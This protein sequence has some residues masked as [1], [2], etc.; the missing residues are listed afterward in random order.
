MRKNQQARKKRERKKKRIKII[1]VLEIQ[2]ST[3]LPI[4]EFNKALPGPSAAESH[5]SPKQATSR[6]T[7]PRRR[8]IK[9]LLNPVLGEKKAYFCKTEQ[10]NRRRRSYKPNPSRDDRLFQQVT[11]TRV[12][13][14]WEEGRVAQAG[15][16]SSSRRLAKASLG[17]PW[18]W[19]PCGIGKRD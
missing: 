14:R 1:L 12:P 13:L 2:L 19:F 3:F 4:P 18:W 15:G 17:Q 6:V 11:S 8:R 16:G 5:A 7:A 10:Q 9:S